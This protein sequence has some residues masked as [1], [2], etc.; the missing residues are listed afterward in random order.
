MIP[1]AISLKYRTVMHPHVSDQERILQ[2]Y[3]KHR[4]SIISTLDGFR[5]LR[6]ASEERWFSEMVYCILTADGNARTALRV[7]RALDSSRVMYEGGLEDI[8]RLIHP[9]RYN[10]TKA[11]YIHAD[12]T[13]L[14]RD[15]VI[16][17]RSML[18]EEWGLDDESAGRVRDRIARDRRRFLGLGMKEAGHFLRNV[19]YGGSLA[20]L[21]IHVLTMMGE[22]GTLPPGYLRD[23]RIRRPASAPAYRKVE[24]RFLE[25]AGELGIPPSHLDL[26]LWGMR[27]GT[28]LK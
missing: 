13:A 9:V 17:L 21:D 12:R 20:I 14:A 7:Q 23:G 19:G 27:S 8:A 5:R 28:I 25:W 22:C 1:T 4:G 15:G 16:R 26:T 6:T 10:T 2:W 3:E 24:E 11:R 18:V